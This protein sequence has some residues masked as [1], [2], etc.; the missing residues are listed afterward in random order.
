MYYCYPRLVDEKTKAVQ[1]SKRQL[2][3]LQILTFYFN[4]HHFLNQKFKQVILLW[5]NT[6]E[7]KVL[8][9]TSDAA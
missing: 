6:L 7:L 5:N 1:A 4:C 8:Q 3:L 9:S 2:E